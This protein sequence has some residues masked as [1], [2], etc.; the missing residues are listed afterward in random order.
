MSSTAKYSAE[1]GLKRNRQT[2][3]IKKGQP[4]EELKN[5]SDDDAIALI[6][7]AVNSMRPNS[8]VKKSTSK[9]THPSAPLRMVSTH[10]EG[11]Q[12][13]DRKPVHFN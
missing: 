2:D 9:R 6:G 11:A 5:A 10:E 3:I 8:N 7:E 1:K 4:Q 12:R 13:F